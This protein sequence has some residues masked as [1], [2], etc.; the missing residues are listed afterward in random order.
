M[1]PLAEVF[2]RQ[3]VY[4]VSSISCELFAVAVTVVL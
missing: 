2:G 1:I 4:S 3:M